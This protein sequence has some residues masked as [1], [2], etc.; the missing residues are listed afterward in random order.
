MR[1]LITG[2]VNVDVLMG[3]VVPWPQQGSEVLVEHYQ[4]RV[5][6]SL[7]NT[8]LALH[9]LG[10][11]AEYY[12]NVGSDSLGE[13]LF[14][15]L[16]K[17]NCS[18]TRSPGPTAV[19]V[20]LTH[21]DGERTFITYEGHFRAFDVVSLQR[22]V[23]SI[24]PNDLF[25]LS[26]YFLL[27]SLRSSARELCNAVRAR[28]GHVLLDTGWPSEGWTQT[29]RDEIKALLQSCNF[30]LPNRE[31]LLGLTACE[32][33]RAGLEDIGAEFGGETVVKLGEAGAS[34][35]EKHR[36]V[37]VP[38]PKVNVVDTVGA[39]DTFNAG[40]IYAF[41]RNASVQEAMLTAV[42]AASATIGSRPRRYATPSELTEIDL[43]T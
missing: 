8:A 29:V 21:P 18:L 15:E 30:F 35:L 16:A 5:G 38:A 17:H 10:V 22:T 11:K 42:H 40:F 12:A 39:G 34:F 7:G 23:E 3:D 4:L 1:I 32:D 43:A 9:A 24:S 2:N 20:G 31:E 27:P 33:V 36:V 14:E 25:M 41:R 26:G 37:R 28:R 19:T 13:W 6:G